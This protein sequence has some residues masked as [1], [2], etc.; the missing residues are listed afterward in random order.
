MQV[1]PT[2]A[3]QPDWYRGGLEGLWAPHLTLRHG[4]CDQSC[5]ACGQVCPTE[6]IRPLQ[7]DERRHA[8]VGTAVLDRDRCLPWAQDQRC[9][10]CREQCPYQAIDF[11]RTRHK[12][13][14]LPVVDPTRCNGCGICEDRCPVDGEAAIVVVPAGE[15]RL[16][17]G[18]YR[19]TSRALGYRLQTRD[20][21]ELPFGVEDR[22]R[23]LPPR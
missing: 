13:A 16:A 19:K 5:N 12:P 11:I 15:L 20:R 3:I 17:S 18:S 10:V 22:P 2:N 21:L 9:L 1:C 6:A 8:R 14:P 7:L 23:G 4:H